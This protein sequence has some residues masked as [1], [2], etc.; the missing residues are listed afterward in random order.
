MTITI[1]GTNGITLPD[2]S[3]ITSVNNYALRNRLINGDMRIDQ[4]N[5]GASQVIVPSANLTY[6]VD[7]WYAYCTGANTVGSRI[8]LS[9]GPNQ[10]AYQFTGNTGVTGVGFGQRM[11]QQN[12]FDLNGANCVMSVY[13]ANSLLPTVNWYVYS[14]STPDTFGTIGSPTKI[15]LASGTFSVSNT[16]TRYSTPVFQLPTSANTGLEVLFTV[17]SQTSGTWIITAAQFENGN[18]PSPFEKRH[19]TQETILSQRY[20]QSFGTTAAFGIA[21][22]GTRFGG[23]WYTPMRIAPAVT[24]SSSNPSSYNVDQYGWTIVVSST[25]ITPTLSTA[26]AEMKT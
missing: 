5:A 10:F 7:R 11:E 15:Q 2:T 16:V 17:G 20:Y 13:L 4:R 12:T 3:I 8:A 1:D 23:L 25:G 22:S 6:T 14:A 24:F 9:S 21:G 26:D 18:N 19:I